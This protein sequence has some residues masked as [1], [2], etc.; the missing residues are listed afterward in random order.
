[1]NVDNM[2]P[3]PTITQILN[4]KSILGVLHLEIMMGTFLELVPYTILSL[5]EEDD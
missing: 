5:M 2:L 1:M 4:L 3:G